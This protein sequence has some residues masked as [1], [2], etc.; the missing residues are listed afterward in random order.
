MVWNKP[1]KAKL[2]SLYDEWLEHGDKTYTKHNNV[3][4]PSKIQLVEMVLTAW[5]S[6]SE[7]TIC[8]SFFCCG[9]HKNAKPTDVTCLR[10]DAPGEGAF[11]LVSK[12]WDKSHGKLEPLVE[13]I[14]EDEDD[15]FNQE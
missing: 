14:D 10:T 2:V 8:T 4:A 7:D 13:E 1:F 3:R 15:I 6:I 12:N 11:E 9:Q 5:K